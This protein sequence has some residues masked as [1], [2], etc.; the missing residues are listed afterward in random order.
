MNASAAVHPE[1]RIVCRWAD[2]AAYHALAHHHYRASSPA[3]IALRQDGSPAI[4]GAFDAGLPASPLVG[5]LVVSM[6]T[7]N[8]QWRDL[9]WPGRFSPAQGKRA[10]ARALN[11]ELRCISRVI[12]D[13]RCRGLGIGSMLVRAYLADP[14]TP[15][16]EAITALGRF[17]PF[18]ERAGM[19]PYTLPP[20][21]RDARLLDAL[22]AIAT[23]PHDLLMPDRTAALL[24]QHPWLGREITLWAASSR[25]TRSQARAADPRALAPLAASAIAIPRTAYAHTAQETTPCH[26]LRPLSRSRRPMPAICPIR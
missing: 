5:V 9:A 1:P 7:L 14:L 6:P 3:T 21:A 25:A 18:F 17:C 20:S 23:S 11:A 24:A 19:M 15:C 26:P 2:R 22:D 10:A 16:T 4:I 8:A 13:P 12:I